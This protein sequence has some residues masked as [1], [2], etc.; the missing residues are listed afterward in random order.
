M[1]I[2]QIQEEMK[3]ISDNPNLTNE[4][5]ISRIK[6]YQTYIESSI[7]EA[8]YNE[9]MVQF[10]QE[11]NEFVN[12]TNGAYQIDEKLSE[13]EMMLR[14]HILESELAKE[15]NEK[16]IEDFTL[17]DLKTGYLPLYE[18]EHGVNLTDTKFAI[19]L[20]EKVED[21]EKLEQKQMEIIERNLG[22]LLGKDIVSKYEEKGIIKSDGQAVLEHT[23][24]SNDNLQADYIK[25]MSKID[26][27]YVNEGKL[28]LQT[29]N[30]T[31]QMLNQLF[32]YYKNGNK[33]V[34]MNVVQQ[35]QMQNQNVV[36]QQGKTL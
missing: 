7:Q 31:T 14:G 12:L 3:K 8:K 33:K 4:E 25:A 22:D 19:G 1:N 28:D 9:Q 2:E 23:E 6:V 30:A 15:L 36:G 18:Q 10:I 34:P 11:A 24:K 16:G 20:Y 27:L 13:N 35:I 21:I 32:T 26:E 29:K 17:G 5:K